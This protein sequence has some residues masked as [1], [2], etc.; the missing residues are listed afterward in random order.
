MI[1]HVISIARRQEYWAN[2]KRRQRARLSE[3]AGGDI[4]D[5]LFY[6]WSDGAKTLRPSQ[7]DDSQTM[8]DHKRPE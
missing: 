8:G 7:C 3:E 6:L 1:K 2:K 5:S 4:K